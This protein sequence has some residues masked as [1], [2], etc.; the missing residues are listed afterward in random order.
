[1]EEGHAGVGLFFQQSPHQG[2]FVAS[3]TPG[4]SAARTGCI[5]KDDLVVRVNEESVA[6]HSL[7]QLRQLVLGPP[8]ST[9]VFT[10]RRKTSD[11]TS[12]CYDVDLMR[13]TGE[14]LDL[15]E[16]NVQQTLVAEDL[17]A[18]L[19]RTEKSC[20][21][22]EADI[23]ALVH[24]P[25]MKVE[26]RRTSELAHEL[27]CRMED[28]RR[29]QATQ[30]RVE[31]RCRELEKRKVETQERLERERSE[32]MKGE[33]LERDRKEQVIRT[34]DLPLTLK[35]PTIILCLTFA[36]QPLWSLSLTSPFITRHRS[37]IFSVD[38]L[39]KGRWRPLCWRSYSMT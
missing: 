10:F 25:T 23:Q 35:A 20:S 34:R 8:G 38:T 19:T 9:V 12:F 6:G 21:A 5:Q 37:T 28:L 24:H 15:V 18:Q 22:M 39:T 14:F 30:L 26:D 31:E 16:R 36:V 17:R 32:R 1:M 2:I 11:S 13:G 29:L 7:A 33:A 3:V 27:K 4:C